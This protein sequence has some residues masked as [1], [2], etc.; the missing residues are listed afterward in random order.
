MNQIMIKK[1]LPDLL[2]LKG[3]PTEYCDTGWLINSKLFNNLEPIRRIIDFI[4][5]FY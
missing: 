4:V 2:V 1:I 3:L 5:F